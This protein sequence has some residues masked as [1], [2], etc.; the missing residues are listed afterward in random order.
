[1]LEEGGQTVRQHIPGWLWAFVFGVGILPVA[2]WAAP[3][4]DSVQE[5]SPGG[6]VDID[7]PSKPGQPD[8]DGIPR[9]G[10]VLQD[11]IWI[12]NWSFEACS[13]TGWTTYDGRILNNG[14][15]FWGLSTDYAGQG[16]IA[17][18]AAVLR[19]HDLCWSQDGYGNIWD[20]SVILKY[21]GGSATLSFVYLADSEAGSDFVT[22]EADSLG[23]SE[24]R[25]DYGVRPG[26]GPEDYR[27]VLLMTDGDQSAGATVSGLGLPDFGAGIH[28][29]YIRFE[30]DRAHSDEDGF[31]LTA[32]QAGLVVDN[33]AVT[34]GTAYNE[35]FEGVLNANV[36]L[37]NT[38]P[39]TPF[40]I[41][42]RLFQHITDND[43]CNENTSCAWLFSDPLRIANFA[44][45]AFGPGSAVV[46][47]WL[48]NVLVSP[49]VSLASTP[50]APATVLSSRVFPGNR[51]LQS[52]IQSSWR[53]RG[54]VRVENTD[55][56][57]LGDSIDCLT[58]W[59]PV[60][61]QFNSLSQFTWFT[62]VQSLAGI[63]DPTSRE[64]Q[65]SFRVSDRQLT[66]AAPP[67]TVN[68]GPGP[69]LDRVRI[70]RMV[71]TGPVILAGIDNR[72]QAQDCFPT[73]QN[74][75]QPGEHFSPSTDRF[76]TCAFSSADDLGGSTQV[77]TGD[78]VT[79]QV[80]DVRGAGGITTV[81][82]YGSITA[83]PHAGKAPAPYTVGGNGFFEVTPDSARSANGVVVQGH[84]FVDL[85]DTYFRGGDLL[86][87][88]WWSTDASAGAAS[89]PVGLT[90]LPASVA[91][92]RAATDGLFEVAYLPVIT[93]PA[94]YLARIAMH[95]SGDL[96]PTAGELAASTQRN[97]IL[98]Y[99][100]GNDSRRSGGPQV[101][102][103]MATLNSLGYNGDY[104]VYDV[105]G[106]GNTNN[107]LAGRASVPQLTGYQLLIEDDGASALI[108]NVPDGIDL[109]SEKLD[110]SQFYR[111]WLDAG[112]ASLA[113]RATLW[114]LGNNTVAE[115]PTNPLFTTYCGVAAV[116][117]DQGLNVNPD[118][119]GQT[120]FSFAPSACLANFTNDVFSLTGGCA[121]GVDPYDGYTAGGTAVVTH[122]YRSGMTLGLGA[123]LMNARPLTNANTILMGFNWADIADDFCGTIPCP[124][125]A[126]PKRT[127][128]SKILACAL[129]PS[130]Q[131]VITPSD[132][133][134]VMELDVPSISALHANVPNPFNPTT[135]IAFDVAQAGRVTLVIHDAAGR[136]VKTLVNED[137]PARRG[138]VVMWDGL[139]EA[140]RRTASGVYFARLVAP[141][142]T[143]TR[144]L[145]LL[146]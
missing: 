108:P 67:A 140:G 128:L 83:G 1:V 130:C 144:K 60:A 145:V 15:N 92:A 78:S 23:L 107:Q 3:R 95:A 143:A 36:T 100:H 25:V 26:D 104:D 72:S 125:P 93:W 4:K 137:L 135:R 124:V 54:K 99:Q 57:T 70:G 146:E 21:S 74:A 38:A 71:T 37:A 111:N 112:A 90:A 12:A 120:S 20:Y 102:S 49:W 29:V 50:S 109:D 118:V 123:V 9:A 34:G 59:S 28:E 63:H 127:L 121:G 19:K 45:M 47:S 117:Q 69:Y 40:G 7:E 33:V 131:Q 11:T 94:A 134:G 66:G 77:V 88:F 103:F 138:H 73:V 32:L 64:I 85:D 2:L 142:L 8:A 75:I 65:V 114:I 76:G 105:S 81:K 17:N 6:T 41:W 106:Y 86:E 46:R 24:S 116:A 43:K 13:S 14:S 35:N 30:S 22:V 48:D 68:P 126:S 82:F 51:Y 122:R 91:A 101:R 44:D 42:A 55:T 119:V 79:V 18:R 56:S 139:D 89:K 52:R 132:D 98:Y 62:D 10:K 5:L 113:G 115:K 53:V 16:S 31:Y 87:Y 96:D 141:D 136:R 133:G 58:P 110:Q 80:L 27:E 39:A 129:S 61:E 97:C 84:W